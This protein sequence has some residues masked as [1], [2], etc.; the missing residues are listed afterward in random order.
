M[1]R[2]AMLLAVTLLCAAA[3]RPPQTCAQEI[4]TFTVTGHTAMVLSVCFSPD[5]KQALSGS[6]DGTIKL[7]DVAAGREIRAFIGSVD[8][9]MAVSFS[10]DGALAL[11]ASYD[12]T[13][14]CRDRPGSPYLYR[15]YRPG[16][17]GE[18]Q[19]GREAGS[20]RFPGYHCEIVGHRDRPGTPRVWRAYRRR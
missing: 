6:I 2:H 20:V 3:T 8:T 4:R 13:V 12:K 15:S 17:V 10:P 19:P 9:V 5:G 16:V 14:G 7:W 1:G 18:F 11:S